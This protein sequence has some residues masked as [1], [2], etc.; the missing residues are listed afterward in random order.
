MLDHHLWDIYTYCIMDDL[1]RCLILYERHEIATERLEYKFVIFTPNIYNFLKDTNWLKQLGKVFHAECEY[2]LNGDHPILHYCAVYEMGWSVQFLFISDDLSFNYLKEKRMRLLI[3][4]DHQ[5]KKEQIK[6]EGIKYG[7]W[8][9]LP[10]QMEFIQ[11]IE[12]F[13]IFLLKSVRLM[14]NH[15]MIEILKIESEILE[16][17]VIS[18][19]QWLS[20]CDELFTFEE[21]NNIKNLVT[22]AKKNL[23]SMREKNDYNRLNTYLNVGENLINNYSDIMDYEMNNAKIIYLKETLLTQLQHFLNHQQTDKGNLI[24]LY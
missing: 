2:K 13:Y 12:K 6:L 8:Y 15:N 23:P 9:E 19:T 16:P 24:C 3:D 22:D 17:I 14:K 18:L 5:F 20:Y 21:V 1:I 10:D 4:K 7:K 11:V